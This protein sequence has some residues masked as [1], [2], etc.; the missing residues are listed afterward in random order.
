MAKAK[1][2]ATGTLTV[3]YQH[4][5]V[6]V[7]GT[8]V[9]QTEEGVLTLDVKRERSSKSDR[10]IFSTSNFDFS[11]VS[12]G[13]ASLYKF[14]TLEEQYKGVTINAITP[15]GFFSGTDED[16]T[17]YLVAPKLWT[18]IVDEEG[19]EAKPAAKG[20][21]EAP[22]PK[23]KKEAEAP[24]KGKKPA[25]EETEDEGEAYEPEVGDNVTFTYEGEEITGEVEAVTAKSITVAETKYLR[26]DI[27]DLV[28]SDAKGE[29]EFEPEVGSF[30]TVTDGEGE[31]TTGEVTKLT[32]KAITVEDEDGEETKFV[33]EDVE[34]AEAEAPAK[35]AKGKKEAAPAKGKKAAEEEAPAKPAKGK[36]EAKPA[37]DDDWEE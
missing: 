6:E 33:R 5:L 27:T 9:D 26:K 22:A 13:V 35:P 34:I 15:E 37:E 19:G 11:M 16:G 28:K 10:K 4:T 2:G 20:K 1:S 29:E 23:G 7:S 14:G 17:A 21:K 36:K 8:L 24:A 25:K 12:E 31:E 18:F 32:A 30:V 3:V